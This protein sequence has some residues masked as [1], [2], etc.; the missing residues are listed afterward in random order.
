MRLG[1]L[2]RRTPTPEPQHERYRQAAV[3]RGV[4]VVVIDAAAFVDGGVSVDV[5]GAL[6][7]GG[8]DVAGLDA[9]LVGA[10]PGP[11]ALLAPPSTVL[12]ASAHQ[13]LA[14]VQLGRHHL[15]RAV[16]AEAER[17]GVRVV[18]KTASWAFDSKP[19][20]LFA[21]LRAGLPVPKSWLGDVDVDGALD[22]VDVDGGVELVAKPLVAGEV[23]RAGPAVRGEPRITQVRVR[24]VDVR[25]VVVFGRCVCA[26]RYVDDDRDDVVDVVDVRARRGFQDGSAPWRSDDDPA[27]ATLAVAAA[28]AV[29]VDVGAVDLKRAADGS[30][31]VLEVN[32]VPVVADLA[33]DLGV[34]VEGAVI[35]AIVDLG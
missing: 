14:R 16:V 20:Q 9:L 22:G 2:S 11:A 31:F 19:A 23:R 15:A 26:G 25:A 34:D 32:R 6:V 35:D 12:S 33:V 29:C 10:L 13:A 30:L 8:V 4:D 3:A 1:I 18:S 5:D 24:G 7:V 27:V 21:L 17:R 28:A